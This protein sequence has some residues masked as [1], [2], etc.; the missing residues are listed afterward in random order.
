MA[1]VKSKKP[2]LFKTSVRIRKDGKFNKRVKTVLKSIGFDISKGV[3][4]THKEAIGDLLSVLKD[5]AP[6]YT[7]TLR[8]S[9]RIS[10][11]E[12]N[13]NGGVRGTI[14]FFATQEQQYRKLTYY[15][16]YYIATNYKKRSE[17]HATLQ[18]SSINPNP[19]AGEEA[20]DGGIIRDYHW[21]DKIDPKA[22]YINLIRNGGGREWLNKSF[23]AFYAV[24]SRKKGAMRVNSKNLEKHSIYKAI[25]DAVSESGA[26]ISSNIVRSAAKYAQKAEKKARIQ[27]KIDEYKERILELE[28]IEKSIPTERDIDVNIAYKEKRYTTNKSFGEYIESRGY[29]TVHKARNGKS[30]YYYS[31]KAAFA[32]SDEGRELRNKRDFIKRHTAKKK[33]IRKRK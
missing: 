7:G 17:Y 13:E 24:Y 27:E 21:F 8:D 16:R 5:N 33:K 25:A 23:K 19:M 20:E 15:Q 18:P 28:K 3:K 29:K 2:V 31:K 12:S 9:G 14:Q 1:N 6:V 22:G 10:K 4:A 30:F 11:M 26:T 32:I